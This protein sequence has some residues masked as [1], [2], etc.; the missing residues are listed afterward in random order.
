MER[1]TVSLTLL[2]VFTVLGLVQ[3]ALYWPHWP[4]RVAT[5][6]GPSGQADGWMSRGPAAAFQ[7]VLQVVFPWF[8]V[9]IGQWV[10]K[11]PNAMI[12]VPHKEYWLAPD[13][14]QESL[15]W[16]AG[17]LTWVAVAMSLFLGCLGHLTYRA[18]QTDQKLP[19]VP[20]LI[21]FTLFM[22]AVLGLA[23]SSLTRFKKGVLG[24]DRR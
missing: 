3:Q 10:G 14:R 11:L 24:T 19:L 17:M 2:G 9:A 1:R 18:N 21:V 13:R 4:E 15:R 5:H 6:F 12:N 7:T 22:A 23:F 20:F 16:M 8:F